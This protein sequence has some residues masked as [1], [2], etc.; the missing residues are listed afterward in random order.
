MIA[1]AAISTSAA[2][3][4]MTAPDGP[5][6]RQSG[7]PE[8]LIAIY[9]EAI[10]GGSYAEAEVLAKR[11]VELSIS[12][13]GR[14]SLAAASALSMLAY[15]Q[16]RQRQLLLAQQN[17]QAAIETI[18]HAAGVLSPELIRPL[19][20][21][22]ET[23]MALQA[24]DQARRTF[25]RAVHL[26][27]V[28]EGPHNLHQVTSLESIAESYRQTGRYNVALDIQ[29]DVLA[30]QESTYGPDNSAMIPALQRH[31]AWMRELGLPNR[32]R[33]T[34][35]RILDLQEEHLA[36]DSVDFVPTLMALGM[37]LRNPTHQLIGPGVGDDLGFSIEEGLDDRYIVR[38]VKPDF[39][40]RRA[41]EIAFASPDSDW[42][43][44]SET[45]LAIGDYYS[46]VRRLVR[47]RLAYTEA[48]NLLSSD[49][50]RLAV[51]AAE[52]EQPHR[53]QGSRL[54]KYFVDQ[55]PVVRPPSDDG[56]SEG[57]ITFR[58]DVSKFGKTVAIEVIEARPS[59][60]TDIEE[61]LADLLGE[62][63]H[64]PR[65]ENGVIVDSHDLLLVH[66]FF[67]RGEYGK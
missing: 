43:L 49:L 7:E 66:E 51:R 15:A 57:S 17:Y 20:G 29:K 26:S 55:E 11:I 45:A 58:Y 50:D 65:L 46:R 48:W 35:A 24:H 53:L 14:D 8:R 18:E 56:F 16:Q 40:L 60:L 62:R 31:A 52:L 28:A 64:R 2:A 44:A 67:Y 61:Q 63:L 5:A 27:H 4:Q 41:M 30:L 6:V 13:A 3:V 38:S 39:Y 1:F 33:N 47:A 36:R 32:E 34:Y 37:S 12:A 23:E 9:S 19:Q 54:P 59:G 10:A 42:H 25:S 21:L 22:G